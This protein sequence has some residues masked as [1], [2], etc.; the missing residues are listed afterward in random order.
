MLLALLGLLLPGGA[1]ARQPLADAATQ[2]VAAPSARLA[3][4]ALWLVER[5]GARLYLLGT[6]HLLPTDVAWRH[7][8][9]AAAMAEADRLVLELAPAE[10]DPARLAGVVAARGL[11]PIGQ[12]LAGRLSP[13]TYQALMAQFSAMGIPPAAVDQMRPWFAAMTLATLTAQASG[14]DPQSGV[15]HTL[16]QWAQAEGVPVDGLETA[17]SQIAALANLPSSLDEA[18]VADT[19]NELAQG[20]GVFDDMLDAWMT[21]DLARIEAVFIDRTRA[22]SPDLH[23]RILLARN[24]AWMGQLASYLDRAET[25]LVAVGAAHLPGEDG[26]LDLLTDAGFVVQPIQ[27]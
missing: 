23:D 20:P 19:L 12:T 3:T 22:L 14:F 8:A 6:F 25:V 24:R 10:M 4:P 16:A 9:V 1:T 26:L 5:D 18:M 27:P 2:A 21:G 15:D 7:G 13:E 17:D 11:F